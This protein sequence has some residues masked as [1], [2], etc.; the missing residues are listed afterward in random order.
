MLE[1]QKDR[2][3]GEYS[4]LQLETKNHCRGEGVLHRKGREGR[5][6][7]PLFQL[8]PLSSLTLGCF[9]V[10]LLSLFD[11]PSPPPILSSFP[12]TLPPKFVGSLAARLGVGLEQDS[13]VSLESRSAEAQPRGWGREAGLWELH[14]PCGEHP[15]SPASPGL[16]APSPACCSVIR[17]GLAPWPSLN[18][19]RWSMGRQMRLS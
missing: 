9:W 5:P 7:S 16:T 8:C 6:A 11:F 2:P 17:E 1:S 14:S 15:E 10:L 18:Q 13:C 3:R 19:M 12:H 4:R